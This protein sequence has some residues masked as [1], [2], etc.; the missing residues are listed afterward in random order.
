MNTKLKQHLIGR[1]HKF[2]A[3]ITKEEL[4]A[5]RKTVKFAPSDSEEQMPPEN[6]IVPMTFGS[7]YYVERWYGILVLDFSDQAVILDRWQQG[8]PYFMDHNSLD[9]RGMIENGRLE[10][11]I[12][13][14]DVKFSRNEEAQEL[15]VDILDGIRPYTSMGF[16]I[17][18]IREMAPEEMPDDLKN[19]CIERQTTAYKVDKWQPYEGSS[20]ALGANPTVGV[21]Y[22][23]LDGNTVQEIID[24]APQLGIEKFSKT[25]T[26][27]FGIATEKP[28]PNQ[29][30]SI[31]S[32]K[33]D[34]MSEKTKTPE[35][36]AQEKRAK[37]ASLI[38]FGKDYEQRVAGGKEF[39]EQ[40][41]KDTVECYAE[42]EPEK[43]DSVFRGSLFTNV[44]DKKPL[45]TPASFVDMTEKDMSQY[46][47]MKVVRHVLGQPLQG[48]KLGIEK[49]IHDTILSRTG[50]EG[51]REGGIKLPFDI[52]TKKIDFNAE[53][54][55]L[56]AKHG[57]R[58]ERFDQTVGSSSGGGYLVGTQ[59]RPQDF[60]ELYLNALV[61][62]FTYLPGLTQNV[63]IPKM[64]GGA[65]I[66]V[67]S[68]EGGGFSET[69]LTFGQLSLSPKEVGAYIDITR[70]LWI[71]SAPSIENLVMTMLM[72]AL[73]RKTNYLALAGSGGSGEPTGAFNT[74]NIGTFDG[75]ALGRAGVANALADIKSANVVAPLMWLLSAATMEILMTRDQTSG[76][77]RWLMDDTG[78]ILTFPSF[79]TEQMAANTLALGAWSEVVVA[80]FGSPEI[81]VDTATASTSGGKR[82]AIYDL[83]DAG[84]KHPG[85]ISYAS[86][87]S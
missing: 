7:E 68:S 79:V 56:L 52:L 25:F 66:T 53:L 47:L 67:A 38:E 61:P 80:S 4:E 45:Q 12:L 70:K 28:K 37:V 35:E 57:I 16:D 24:L 36:L 15:L 59:H 77:G 54:N 74:A 51:H 72:Q 33:E 30:I 6:Q 2:A 86:S 83:I 69:A 13:R 41:A 46:S 18:Q 60:I 29:S 21:E 50:G 85:A 39:I 55:F 1:H 84:L 81:N 9:Q 48:E 5:I 20:V 82:I 71:Q 63:D 65:T 64:T 49:E 14:G 40:L 19:L 73:A 44:Q 78:N 26:E 42:T 34:I 22:D 8:A 32:H 23:Y 75:S 31:N 17:L 76:F 3:R 11:K 87:V 27:N 62:G 10:N 43:V 58:T